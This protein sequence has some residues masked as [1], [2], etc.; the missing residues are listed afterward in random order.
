MSQEERRT[1]S[2]RREQPQER[3]QREQRPR[4]KR[5]K[6]FNL[7]GTLLY[8]AFVIGVSTLLAAVGW[9][10]A[11][12]LLAL[13]KAEH[14]AIITL[15]DDIFTSRE[16]TVETEDGTET[17]TELVVDLDYVI[18]TLKENGIIEYGLLFRLYSI[19][20]DAQVKMTPGTYQL[21]TDMDYRAIVT[22]LGSNSASRQQVTV[23]IP[24]GFTVAQIFQRLEDEGVSTVEKLNEMAATHDYAFSFLQEIPLGE[25]TRLEGY[26]FPDTYDFYMGED[27]LTV[28]N[29]MLV[30]FDRR[31]TDEMRAEAQA[32]GYSVRDIVIIASM[33][34]RETD[35]SDRATISSVIYNRWQNTG[36]ETAGYLG[37]DAT[38]VYALGRTIT[39]DD[40]TA[41]TPY[42][43]YTNQGLPP[44]PI[45]NPGMAS[46]NAAME[47][48]STNYYYYAL[49]NDGTHSF[50]R[51][52]SEQQNFIA[53]QRAES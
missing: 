44:G 41:D 31:F 3:T 14:S 34:E 17:E 47:P 23:T 15:P 1:S 49:G 43:T 28:I 29:K 33:I 50:F 39:Q 32:N 4:K 10:A 5:K 20:S 6:G 24:E 45:S 13:N 7:M 51:T 36:A 26:L 21:D 18:D 8:V 27:P 40:Y 2:G 38:L 19:F 16:V 52:L 11:N 48:E 37:V 9:V 42:N 30:N 53:Q 25:P 46:I 12:D 35:G 22:N